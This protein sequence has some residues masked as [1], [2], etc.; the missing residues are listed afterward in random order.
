M[1][2]K[3][4]ITP[5]KSDYALV[6]IQV[7]DHAPK[8]LASHY[9]CTVIETAAIGTTIVKI[10]AVDKYQGANGHIGGPISEAAAINSVVLM[11]NNA[12]LV[13]STRDE[14]SDQNANI[15]FTIVEDKAR[16]DFATDSPTGAIR[17]TGTLNHE[18]V[19]EVAFSVYV[20][21]SQPRLSASTSSTVT[22]TV[23]DINDVPPRFLLQDITQLY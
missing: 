6:I 3:D 7:Q 23:I 8:F 2:V 17:T 14:D 15:F 12:P 21:N 20:H 4:R 19:S 18:V 9:C 1:S 16:M 22:I 5:T 10:V 11:D 13:I